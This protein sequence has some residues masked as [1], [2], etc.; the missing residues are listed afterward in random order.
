MMT[1]ELGIRL[2]FSDGRQ[3]VT[4]L[5]EINKALAEIGSRIWP[6]DLRS[7]PDEI[8]KLL[9]QP[10]LTKGG[11]DRLL[12]RFLLS[13]ERLLEIITSAG[14][15]PHVPG[16]G[17]LTTLVLPYNYKYPQLFVVEEGIDYSRFDRFHVN[18]AKDG[19]SV[20]EVAQILSGSGFVNHH[21][22]PNGEILSLYV[23]CPGE[24]AGWIL[25]YDGGYPHIGSISGAQPGT[26]AL[27]QVIGPETWEMRYDV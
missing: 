5:P 16:G 9:G 18:I 1:K 21:R 19:T 3:P 24:D 25:T 17:A 13:R 10:T 20:D 4:T 14:R 6:L 7:E 11:S 15:E 12:N 27:V 26:K 22:S 23:D 8:R 2:E